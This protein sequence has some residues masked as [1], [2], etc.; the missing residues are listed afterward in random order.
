MLVV[1]RKL[2]VEHRARTAAL[3]I[4]HDQAAD[5]HML[6][7]AARTWTARE[8]ACAVLV[9]QLDRWAATH[10]PEA[11]AGV[12]HTETLGQLV[13]RLARVWMRSQLLADAG[14]PATDPQ[15]RVAAEQVSELCVAYDELVGDLVRGRR[16]LPKSQTPTGPGGIA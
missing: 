1:A 13:D 15:V 8:T 5:D 3:R 7:A 11:P 2:A 10:L 12:L 16:R 14:Q 9:D 6:A 4:I